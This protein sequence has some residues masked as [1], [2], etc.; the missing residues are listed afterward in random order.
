MA[1]PLLYEINTRCWMRALSERAGEPVELGTVPETEF[2][3]W[4]GL[5]FTHIWLMGIWS[6]GRRVRNHALRWSS[7]GS[8]GAALPDWCNA[9]VLGSPY[10]IADYQVPASMGGSAGLE[11]FRN[12]LHQHGL[13]LILD[14]VPNH[15]GLDHAWLRARPEL[16]VQSP[17]PVSGMT[18]AFKTDYGVR[19]FAHGKD[20]YF[21]AWSDTVQLDYRRPDT[22]AAMID[23]LRAVSAQCDGVRCDMAML[24]L[25]G[26]FNENW[27]NFPCSGVAAGSEFWAETISAVRSHKPDFVFV[28][29]AYWDLEDKLRQLG[30]DFAYNKRVYDAVVERR[31]AQL[32]RRLFNTQAPALKGSVHFLENHD[33]PRISSLLSLPEH[34]AAAWLILTLPG[35]CLLHEGQLKGAKVR[36]PVQLGRR[37]QETGDAEIERLYQEVLET[38][39]ACYVRSG[40]ASVLPTRPLH[41]EDISSGHVV[42]V[43]WRK[44]ADQGRTFHVAVTNL[45]AGSARCAVELP[46]DLVERTWVAADLLGGPGSRK[47]NQS[48]RG[49]SLEFT[50]EL[51][52]H[53]IQLL[54]FTAASNPGAH[55]L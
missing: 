35:M 10:A 28:A 19:H 45:G 1:H 46:T 22:R 40:E 41:E 43:L 52:G 5:G 36:C 48:V 51:A 25:N 31:P 17:A 42:A 32:H 55:F 30:F 34:R 7:S 23:V 53:G 12:S 47:P 21:P 4:R 18:F 16:F 6:V 14:F 37:C 13:Q 20:P 2:K 50:I 33:E 39:K 54:E 29:E 11:K 8:Y 44:P 9:D 38:L 24:L 26:I 3:E 15:L 49:A 27:R